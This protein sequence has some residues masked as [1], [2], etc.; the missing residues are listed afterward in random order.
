M[1]ILHPY[2]NNTNFV[3]VPFLSCSSTFTPSSVGLSLP[4]LYYCT[5]LLPLLLYLPILL[6]VPSFPLLFPVLFPQICIRVSSQGLRLLCLLTCSSLS[7][8]KC[9]KPPPP[10]KSTPLTPPLPFFSQVSGVLCC[11]LLV[12]FCSL[13]ICQCPHAFHVFI[14]EVQNQRNVFLTLPVFFQ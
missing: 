9:D 12:S 2:Q 7:Q 6:S 3:L 4:I 8:V 14:F 13:L 11:R 5:I 10:P 1:F